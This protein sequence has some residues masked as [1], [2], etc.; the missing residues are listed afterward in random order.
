MKCG[1]VGDFAESFQG[2]GGVLSEELF[3][4]VF[5]MSGRDLKACTSSALRF[6]AVAVDTC[7]QK[8]VMLGLRLL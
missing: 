6:I 3:Q 4:G 8:G 7:L 2:V 5:E 1:R